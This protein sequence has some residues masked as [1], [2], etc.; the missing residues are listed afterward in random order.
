MCKLISFVCVL[1]ALVSTSYAQPHAN[2]SY[3]IDLSNPQDVLIGNWER[4][5]DTWNMERGSALFGFSNTG[6]TLDGPAGVW[7]PDGE[8]KALKVV[9]DAVGW[10]W[11][12]QWR[13]PG[14]SNEDLNTHHAVSVIPELFAGSSPDMQPSPWNMFEMDATVLSNEWIQDEDPLTNPSIGLTLILNAGGPGGGIFANAGT[15]NLP[16][17][18]TTHC[19]WDLTAGIQQITDIWNAGGTAWLYYELQIYPDIAGYD[20]STTGTFY[21][22]AAFLTPEPATIAL[23]GL[24]GLSLLR[25]RRKR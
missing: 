11:G 10:S 6:A 13:A 7:D 24:G 5:Y 3:P 25:I 1:L 19:I 21:L 15:F 12:L 4:C 9:G 14:P 18:V 20:S 2:A 17:D 23:L 8:G 22:D 16:M